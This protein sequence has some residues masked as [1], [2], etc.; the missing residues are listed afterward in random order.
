MTAKGSIAFA[1]AGLL[2]GGA[3]V[4]GVAMAATS[5]TVINACVTTK[6]GAL[7]IVADG[8]QCKTSETATSWNQIG[9]QGLQGLQ[10]EQGP[11]GPQGE[12]GPQGPAGSNV[13][14]GYD[15]VYKSMTIPP[16]LTSVMAECAQNKV[17]VGGGH[18]AL[19]TPYDSQP[20]PIQ[21][22]QSGP[23]QNVHV[24]VGGGTTY[25]R[26]WVA[27]FFNADTVEHDVQVIG[28]CVPYDGT[29]NTVNQ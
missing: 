28:V 26:G 23:G 11:Q 9:P 20:P 1:A 18:V 6:T 21:I 29:F 14:T 13:I 10:G 7:R 17:P 4:G 27:S 12:V 15:R 22:G 19:G 16:G 24:V 25:V 8:V 2:I 3:L 5:T